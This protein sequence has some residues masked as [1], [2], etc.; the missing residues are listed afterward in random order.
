M[1][2]LNEIKEYLADMLCDETKVFESPD[3]ASAFIGLTNGDKA[4]YDYDLMV[5]WVK[6]HWA[7]TDDEARMTVECDKVLTG[8]HGGPEIVHMI[9]GL[10]DADDIANYLCDVGCDGAIIFVN[11]DYASAF[12]G[13]TVDGRVV[14]DYNCMVSWLMTEWSM[15]FDS[16]CDYIDYN[17]SYNPEKG[18]VVLYPALYI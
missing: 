15:S 6:E 14:Y 16:A 18:P 10:H 13:V 2:T 4:V 9:S 3:Y 17:I 5:D 8:L 12:V 7:M 1:T 11:P